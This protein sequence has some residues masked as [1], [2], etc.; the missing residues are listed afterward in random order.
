MRYAI[1]ANPVSGH[2]SVQAKYRKLKKLADLLGDAQIHGF[3]TASA[4]EFKSCV[5]NV[6]RKAE[7]IIIAGGDGT[8]HDV[9]NTVKPYDHCFSVVPMGTGNALKYALKIPSRLEELAQNIQ[10]D[11]VRFMD[12]I[13]HEESGERAYMASV[14]IDG[15]IL[16][17]KKKLE[18]YHWKSQALSFFDYA[19]A[20][21]YAVCSY[22]RPCAMVSCFEKQMNKLNSLI[23]TKIPNY[24]MGLKIAPQTKMDD[25]LL[26]ATYLTGGILQSLGVVLTSYLGGNRFGLNASM[27]RISV[28]TTSPVHLQLDGEPKNPA[29]VFSFSVIK[30]AVRWV[31]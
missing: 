11:Q 29:D 27:E 4:C 30:R 26:H 2:L 5:A 14:G 9:I 21:A 20:T 15:C 6:A 23:V 13:R 18:P 25:G 8:V 17:A 12:L 24:G 31:A 22:A 7:H 3:D 16:N 28:Q 10:R 19:L 1:L